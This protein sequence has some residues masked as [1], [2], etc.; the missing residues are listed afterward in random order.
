MLPEVS[1]GVINNPLIFVEMQN[2]MPSSEHK[3]MINKRIMALV[4]EYYLPKLRLLRIKAFTK[5]LAF[6]RP[7]VKEIRHK[8]Y[9]SKTFDEGKQFFKEL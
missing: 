6:G 9:A 8:I 5:Y 2:K 3:K 4:E 1:R 7:Y